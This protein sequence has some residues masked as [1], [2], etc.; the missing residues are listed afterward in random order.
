[1]TRGLRPSRAHVPATR[2]Y[3]FHFAAA[4][5]RARYGWTGYLGTHP[6]PLYRTRDQVPADLAAR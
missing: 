5:Q 1:M 2:G 3:G 4:R 6:G